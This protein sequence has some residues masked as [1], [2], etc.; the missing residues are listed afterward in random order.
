MRLRAFAFIIIGC[1]F[2]L[3]NISIFRDKSKLFPESLRPY[4]ILPQKM[5]LIQ[6]LLLFLW[7]R[8]QRTDALGRKKNAYKNTINKII[9]KEGYNKKKIPT[10]GNR[11]S[12]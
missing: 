9:P 4:F 5:G 7:K 12:Q 1:I 6:N 8:T 10:S 2:K 3:H 11:D